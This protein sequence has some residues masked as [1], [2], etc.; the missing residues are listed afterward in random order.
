MGKAIKGHGDQ[1]RQELGQHFGGEGQETLEERV[2]KPVSEDP[3][4]PGSLG[5]GLCG[6]HRI[7]PHLRNMS[8]E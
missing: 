2:F 5:Q 6:G 4:I 1:H 3:A 8:A 7:K